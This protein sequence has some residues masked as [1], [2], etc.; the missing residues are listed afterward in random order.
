MSP[1]EFISKF[2]NFK[3]IDTIDNNISRVSFEF[4]FELHFQLMFEKND[5]KLD[6]Y[7]FDS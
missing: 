2:W 4:R 3:S 5:F 6:N 7:L 1:S